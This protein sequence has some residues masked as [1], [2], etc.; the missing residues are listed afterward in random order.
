VGILFR[1]IFREIVVSTL[2]GTVLFTFV[3][4]L[5]SVGRIMELMVGPSSS[6][7]EVLSLI[8][9]ILPQTLR[10]TIP[11]GVLVGVLVGLGRLSTDGEIT[12]MRAAGIPSRKVAAPI[13]LWALA[14]ALA[15]AATT[16]YINPM[17]QRELNRRSETLKISQATAEIQPRVFIEDFPN[18][19]LYV[20]DVIPGPIVRWQGVFLADTRPPSERGSISG[21]QFEQHLQVVINAP[22]RVIAR[23]QLRRRVETA[24]LFHARGFAG[25]PDAGANA[26]ALDQKLAR[27]GGQRDLLVRDIETR[28]GHAVDVGGR[29]GLVVPPEVARLRADGFRQRHPKPGLGILRSPAKRFARDGSEIGVGKIGGVAKRQRAG[30]LLHAN[31]LGR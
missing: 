31:A 5:R 21:A 19:V 30:A 10:F 1:Y 3:L 22:G 12:A 2:I 14:G 20:R 8:L 16:L 23:E 9:L 29:L 24:L 26:Y 25:Q 28:V 17:A 11:I 18:M 15:C 7:A 27:A 4:F 6:T 13:F